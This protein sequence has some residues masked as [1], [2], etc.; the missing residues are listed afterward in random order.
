MHH[1][2]KSE[3]HI[4]GQK[5]MRQSNSTLSIDRLDHWLVNNIQTPS[6]CKTKIFITAS[7]VCWLYIHTKSLNQY[8]LAYQ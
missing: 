6:F 8:A 2:L 4:Y 1:L 5:A 7:G 3:Y